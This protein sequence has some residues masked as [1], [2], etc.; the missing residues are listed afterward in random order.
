MFGLFKKKKKIDIISPIVG[1][2]V[3]ITDVPD[4]VFA[5]K[6]LGDG[7]AFEPS[8]G[9][10]YSP[11]DG[12]IIQKFPT[13]HAVGIKTAE[14]LEL[15]LHIGIDTVGMKGEGFESFVEI[16]DKVKAGQKLISFDIELIKEKAKSIITPMVITN[17]DIVEDFNF[18]YGNADKGFVAASI[19]LK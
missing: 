7:M 9:V 3:R 2:A 1:K 14:G 10:L 13:N 4:E 15:L 16:G 19:N 11:V 5:S 18:N 12:E 8:E 6:M 17:M